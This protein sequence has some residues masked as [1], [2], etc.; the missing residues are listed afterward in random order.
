MSERIDNPETEDQPE[1]AELEEIR[2]RILDAEDS[3]FWIEEA[4][5]E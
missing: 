1:D 2:Q 5:D 3:E 4:D